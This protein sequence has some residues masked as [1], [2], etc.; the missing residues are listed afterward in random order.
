MLLTRFF[1]LVYSS[2]H[3]SPLSSRI[4]TSRRFTV[5]HFGLLSLFIMGTIFPGV[6]LQFDPILD[7]E[8]VL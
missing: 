2:L 5:R 4:S 3:F 8:I 1:S 7:P 6:L